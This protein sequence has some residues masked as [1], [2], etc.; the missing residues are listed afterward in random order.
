MTGIW[1]C[2]LSMPLRT[3]RLTAVLF[4]IQVRSTGHAR[5]VMLNQRRIR[6]MDNRNLAWVRDT[7]TRVSPV[8]EQK[9][10]PRK[11]RKMTLRD[12][13]RANGGK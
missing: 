1:T 7:D 12:H 2:A 5:C 10:K 9:R 8:R 11:Q 4:T 3:I 6:R 13:R